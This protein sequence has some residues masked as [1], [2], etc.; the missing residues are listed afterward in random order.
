MYLIY[1]IFMIKYPYNYLYKAVLFLIKCGEFTERIIMDKLNDVHRLSINNENHLILHRDMR[2]FNILN[3]NQLM[4]RI[5]INYFE[6]YYLNFIDL[7]KYIFKTVS[8]DTDQ[9]MKSK[10]MNIIDQSLSSYINLDSK[11]NRGDTI[12]LSLRISKS[13]INQFQTIL[14]N[15]KIN[16]QDYALSFRNCIHAYTKLSNVERE[17]IILKDIYTTLEQSIISKVEINFSFNSI[18]I[19]CKPL[20]IVKPFDD[21]Y[22]F[23]ISQN[24]DSLKFYPV[25]KITDLRITEDYFFINEKLQ[26]QI[27]RMKSYGFNL[28]DSEA[29]KSLSKLSELLNN[30]DMIS[31]LKNYDT[32]KIS[33]LSIKVK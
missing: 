2:L 14:K 32:N 26:N 7:K 6:T 3:I 23:L 22:L 10:V 8:K 27:K 20:L 29:R 25:H 12:R 31:F 15:L 19:K 9:S 21:L 11:M 18:T 1:D 13:F 4:N 33:N 28:F 5:L 24:N 16:E 30:D 17:K